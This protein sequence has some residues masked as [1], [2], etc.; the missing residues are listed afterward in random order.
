MSCH[1][2]FT[3]DINGWTTSGTV[4]YST[5]EN[6]SM[7]IDGNGNNN[8][9]FSNQGSRL[10]S[11]PYYANQTLTIEIHWCADD[12]WESDNDYLRTRVNNSIVDTDYDGGG[13]HS[14]TFTAP[15]APNGD[16]EIEF[17]TYVSWINEDAWIDWLTIDS[18]PPP[19]CATLKR[20]R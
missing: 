18:P 10:Y 3:S 9:S 11:F 2:Q 6:G 16:F 14:T 7:F 1:E 5:A 8:G 15:V 20:F 12:E 13:C 4:N 19:S 17:S